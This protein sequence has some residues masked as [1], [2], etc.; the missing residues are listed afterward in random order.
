MCFGG[1]VLLLS[2]VQLFCNLMDCSPQGSS[3]H[4]VLQARILECVA[5]PFSKGSSWTRD[6]THVSCIG[7]RIL[8]HCA[9]REGLAIL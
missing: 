4:G 7:K 1:V 9:T 2:R 8:Y 6:R 5:I 3:V